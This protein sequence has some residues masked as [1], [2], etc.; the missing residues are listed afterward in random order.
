[1]AE[2]RPWRVR[3]RVLSV[4]YNVGSPCSVAAALGFVAVLL[5]PRGT[6]HGIT[7]EFAAVRHR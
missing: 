7:Q 5:M 1:M 3:C 6:R 4:G 2:L